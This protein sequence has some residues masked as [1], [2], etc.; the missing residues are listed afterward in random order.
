MAFPTVESPVYQLT[1]PS[2][3]K[4]VKYRSFL[5]KEQRSLLMA[6]NGSQDDILLAMQSAVSACTFGKLD[7]E[8][9][10]NFD[11]EYIFLQIRGKSIGET[12]ELVLTCKH[13]STKEDFKLNLNDVKV[14]KNTAHSK[15]IMLADNLGVMMKYPT[16]AQ[17][18]YLTL[19]YDTKV[20]FDT[21]L[22]CI[23]SVFTDET[24]TKTA[25]EPREELLAFIDSLSGNQMELIEEF[26]KTMPVLKHEFKH[27]C[28]SCGE[29][30][31]FA[32]EGI[33]AFFH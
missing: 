24:I 20:V 23:E 14:V 32:M 2:T 6:V 30:T 9:L 4:K 33:E 3:N 28:K 8:N 31:T 21:L 11:L 25:D 7:V 26:F 10:P 18:T 16:T 5:V 22:E 19:N 27:K 15:K 13:C 17:L 1:L 12:V 29:S